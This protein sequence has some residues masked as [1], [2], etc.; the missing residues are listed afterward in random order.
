MTKKLIILLLTLVFAHSLSAQSNAEYFSKRIIDKDNSWV[1]TSKVDDINKS[2]YYYKVYKLE[3]KHNQLQTVVEYYLNH[4]LRMKILLDKNDRKVEETFYNKEGKIRED[5]SGISTMKYKYSSN[6]LVTSVSFYNKDNDRAKNVYGIHKYE[7]Q[8]DE[9]NRLIKTSNYE[10]LDNLVS[11]ADRIAIVMTIYNDKKN[12][13]QMRYLNCKEELIEN[14]NGFAIITYEFDENGN[15]I[16]EKYYGKDK[17]LKSNNHGIAII[18]RKYDNHSNLILEQYYNDQKVLQPD[19]MGI[20]TYTY[21]YDD[22]NNLIKEAFYNDKSKLYEP[23]NKYA[24][25]IYKYNKR[26]KIIFKAFY[27][28]KEHLKG[29]YYG[30]AIYQ[31][32]YHPNGKLA[33]KACFDENKLLKTVFF[34][35]KA[36]KVIKLLNINVDFKDITTKVTVITTVDDKGNVSVEEYYDSVNNKKDELCGIHK[37]IYE[38]GEEN[39]ISGV[40]TFDKKDDKI[41]TIKIPFMK[42]FVNMLVEYEKSNTEDDFLAFY[43]K[44]QINPSIYYTIIQNY[45]K[46]LDKNKARRDVFKKMYTDIKSGDTKK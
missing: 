17:S 20:S 4:S 11:E 5:S 37:A 33:K 18:K 29:D 41:A 30:Y 44:H 46:W 15:V 19:A 14:Q 9:N 34:Y 27:S 1:F 7:Y 25:G 38:Y 10:D 39:R 2:Q 43:K 12:I 16:E 24:M 31:L 40:N 8:Y 13:K 22:R 45:S 32:S 3:N 36:G 6:G 23:N 42:E 28:S 26:N 35:D 21:Q